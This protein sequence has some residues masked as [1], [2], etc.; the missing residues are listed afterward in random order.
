[1]TLDQG[2]PMTVTF[3]IHIGSCTHLVKCTYQ[4]WH[5]RLQW[6]LKI[7]LFYLFPKGPNL[8]LLLNRSRSIWGHYLNK[9]GSTWAPNDAY[10]VSRWS[11]FKFQRRRFLPHM[12]MVAI[13]GMWPG[14]FEQTFVLPS[15]RS[16]IWNLNL[17]GQVV[18]EKKMFKVWLTMTYDNVQRRPI[19]PISSPVNLRPRWANKHSFDIWGQMKK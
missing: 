17:I 16:F 2:Q 11:A 9:L 6:F 13:L 14:T 18:S 1:M 12:S 8:T 19:Y 7:P 5:H 10:Q 3:D 4:L 15:Q